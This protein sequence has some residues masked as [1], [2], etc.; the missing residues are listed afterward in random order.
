MF[1]TL[2]AFRARQVWLTGQ[3]VHGQPGLQLST[4]GETARNSIG[5]LYKGFVLLH[6]DRTDAVTRNAPRFADLGQEPT[7]FSPASMAD[8]QF[9]PNRRAKLATFPRGA[10]FRRRQRIGKHFR[11]RA[12]F[13]PQADEGSG[14]LFSI[15][16]RQNLLRHV[17]LIAHACGKGGMVQKAHVVFGLHL[18]GA[19]GVAPFGDNLGTLQQTLGLAH[20]GRRHDQRRD[21]FLASPTGAAR[22]VEK[23]F[24]VG[25]QVGMDHQLQPRKV[26]TTGRHVGGDA[27]AG[28]TVA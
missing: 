13:A 26:D 28:A 20:F 25:R 27:H 9:E 23:G 22:T 6:A 12:A 21:A 11:G 14:N 4:V 5:D 8:R 16:A 24:R 1:W 15:K 17:R 2:S 7:C 19:G 3:L 18:I 10:R